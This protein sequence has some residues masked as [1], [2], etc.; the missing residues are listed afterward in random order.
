M[1]LRDSPVLFILFDS[2]C[3]SPH[4]WHLFGIDALR[5][6]NEEG[7]GGEADEADQAAVRRAVSARLDRIGN[8]YKNQIN[9]WEL[10]R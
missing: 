9:L 3:S 7:D 4:D 1:T 10:A 6:E 8:L 2:S 5:R